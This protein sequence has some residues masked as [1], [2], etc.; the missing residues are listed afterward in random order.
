MKGLLRCVECN[1]LFQMTDYDS[2]PE[3]QVTENGEIHEIPRD[4]RRSFLAYHKGHKIERLKVKEGSLISDQPYME[5]IKT[6]YFKA[7]NGKENFVI[8]RWRDSI[9][10][11]MRYELIKGDIVLINEELG[12]QVEEISKQLAYDF[13]DEPLSEKK[14]KLFIKSL[15]RIVARLNPGK[16]KVTLW[17][18]SDPLV[19]YCRLDKDSVRRL[20]ESSKKVFSESEFK[21]IRKFIQENNHY[22]DPIT[23]RRRSHFAIKAIDKKRRCDDFLYPA[24]KER[25]LQI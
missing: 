12:V 15:Q 19:A 5:P 17:D 8:K 13:K 4:E 11:P 24:P 18:S 2:S 21:R 9:D 20:I 25:V 14:I 10:S 16:L 3:Y 22:N 7:T 1:E 23:L 6:T